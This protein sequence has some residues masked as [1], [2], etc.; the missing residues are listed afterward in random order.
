MSALGI[1]NENLP[2]EIKKGVEG[3]VMLWHTWLSHCD[4]A[5][6]GVSTRR[7]G[8]PWARFLGFG[9]TDFRHI[10]GLRSR[11]SGLA[12]ADARLSVIQEFDTGGLKGTDKLF[13]RLRSAT[14]LPS[15]GFEPPYRRLGYT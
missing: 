1:N 2:V 15:H 11:G 4:N 7:L 9:G 8:T 5:S 6:K 13:D 12:K 14:K 10:S 3:R